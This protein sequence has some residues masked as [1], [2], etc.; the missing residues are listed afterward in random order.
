MNNYGSFFSRLLSYAQSKGVKNTSDLAKKLGY[1]KPERLYRLKRDPEARP[2]FEVLEDL[3]N[4]FESLNLRWLITGEG[5]QEITPHEEPEYNMAR[6]PE[7]VYL[8]KAQEQEKLLSEKER[9]I[10][11][12]QATIGAL[13]EAYG[14]LKLRFEEIKEK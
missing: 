8:T 11:Q 12:Q 10:A 7:G 13:N 3:T 5:Q 4:L 14:Q 9:I 1:D 2:S 6:E